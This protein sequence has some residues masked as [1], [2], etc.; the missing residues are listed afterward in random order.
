MGS[1]E[2]IHPS[3]RE[4]RA[5]LGPK[6]PQPGT[7]ASFGAKQ[8]LCLKLSASFV[9]NDVETWRACCPMPT[10]PATIMTLL[11]MLLPL[12]ARQSTRRQRSQ[13]PTTTSTGKMSTPSL[14][15]TLSRSS[16]MT[17]TATPTSTH[18]ADAAAAAAR[19]DEHQCA[20]A[21]AAASNYGQHSAAAVAAAATRALHDAVEERNIILCAVPGSLMCDN[22]RGLS[23]EEQAAMRG[24]LKTSNASDGCIAQAY[25][26]RHTTQR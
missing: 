8:L 6:V 20:A 10:T 26:K 4:V 12:R 18:D 3:Q 7:F 11:L 9:D 22:D 5:E 1:A 2:T 15:T 14:M 19:D 21:A 23:A 24:L 16:A 25:C 13:L 17:S